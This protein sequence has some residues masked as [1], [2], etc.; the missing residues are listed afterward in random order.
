MIK[1]NTTSFVRRTCSTFHKYVHQLCA[2]ILLSSILLG[3]LISDSRA[4]NVDKGWASSKG[5]AGKQDEIA[6]I[7]LVYGW[8]HDTPICSNLGKQKNFGQVFLTDA[9]SF[10]DAQKLYFP[11][12]YQ[13]KAYGWE[14]F[15]KL[16][17]DSNA[18]SI[19]ESY[20]GSKETAVKEANQ[21]FS[22]SRQRFKDTSFPL[23]LMYFDAYIEQFKPDVRTVSAGAA[24]D[25]W[26]CLFIPCKKDLAH[27]L[28]IRFLHSDAPGDPVAEVKGAGSDAQEKQFEAINRLYKICNRVGDA[29]GDAG[30]MPA[31]LVTATTATTLQQACKMYGTDGFQSTPWTVQQ[32]LAENKVHQSEAEKGKDSALVKAHQ[33]LAKIISSSPVEMTTLFAPKAYDYKCIFFKTKQAWGQNMFV[34]WQQENKKWGKLR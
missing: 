21:L 15:Q 24:G 10:D 23:S 9:S 12:R 22:R 20:P 14:K 19:A 26:V 18:R 1:L 2:L 34:R 17:I 29:Y 7:Y 6:A 31:P 27:N 11:S 16:I 13:S 5:I 28:F 4:E 25:Y 32:F 33:D 3:T 8:A 30:A